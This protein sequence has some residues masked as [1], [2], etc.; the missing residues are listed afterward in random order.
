MS[1]GTKMLLANLPSLACVVSAGFIA[2]NGRSGWG[3]FLFC[4][5]VLHSRITTETKTIEK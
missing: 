1:I 5:V 2:H 4:A 3:W